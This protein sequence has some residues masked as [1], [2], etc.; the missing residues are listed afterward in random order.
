MNTNYEEWSEQAHSLQTEVFG[1]GDE[2]VRDIYDTPFGIQIQEEAFLPWSKPSHY[3]TVVN[4]IL[5]MVKEEWLQETYGGRLDNQR[6][7]ED[8]FGIPV[9]DDTEDSDGSRRAWKFLEI[10]HEN[11]KLLKGEKRR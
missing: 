3:R 6:Y 9:F 2:W 5:P 8:G 11:L 4:V 10:E 7:T 1:R